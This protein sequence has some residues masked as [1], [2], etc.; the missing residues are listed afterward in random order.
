LTEILVEK[1]GFIPSNPRFV[2]NFAYIV[3]K[4]VVIHT[5]LEILLFFRISIFT[6]IGIK[7]PLKRD[8]QIKTFK[9]SKYAK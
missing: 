7:I 3:D 9:E 8:N 2:D 5:L 6:L 1:A 4:W